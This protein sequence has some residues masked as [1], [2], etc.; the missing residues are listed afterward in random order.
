MFVEETLKIIQMRKS[1]LPRFTTSLPYCLVFILVESLSILS[2]I[3]LRVNHAFK[4]NAR[5]VL[6]VASACIQC[7]L[8]GQA[9]IKADARRK[10][11]VS[12]RIIYLIG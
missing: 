10:S 2:T 8:N 4:K 11:G 3:P 7:L 12:K 5:S 9:G 1:I 6:G